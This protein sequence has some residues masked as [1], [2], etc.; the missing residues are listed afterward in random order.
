M[1]FKEFCETA[2]SNDRVAIL[3]DCYRGRVL[4]PAK[5]CY[6]YL[7]DPTDERRPKWADDVLQKEV[8]RFSW[9]NCA[10]VGH[11]HFVVNFK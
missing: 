4:Y 8:D 7:L 11:I 3:D 5:A 10:D 6:L 2:L 1:T 9:D